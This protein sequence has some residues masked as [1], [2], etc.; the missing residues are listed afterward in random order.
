M[1]Q[2]Q[3]SIQPKALITAINENLNRY[4]Y[5]DSRDSAKQ[6]FKVLSD[7]QNSPFMKID[8]GES[9][10]IY[11]DLCL[12]SS[13]H[14]GKLNF[15][16]FRKGL[17]MMMLGIHNRLEADE[18]LNVMHSET[19]ETMFHIPGLHQCEEG[20]NVLVCGMRQTGPGV[21]SITLMYLDPEKYAESVLAGNKAADALAD[22]SAQ[23]DS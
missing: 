3:V 12:D 17:A 6:L 4:F 5:A 18:S 16:K 13:L 8:M 10:E 22:K 21:A 11:C 9:G 1:S 20:T 2:E 23:T 15:S 14:V 19:G 7:G